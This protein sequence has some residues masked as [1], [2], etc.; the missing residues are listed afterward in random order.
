MELLLVGAG[1]TEAL[2]ARRVPR[3][4]RGSSVLSLKTTGLQA[5]SEPGEGL[6]R[7]REG[8]AETKLR[9]LGD[10]LDS[11]DGEGASRITSDLR[12]RETERTAGP[13]P[14]TQPLLGGKGGRRALICSS[15]SKTRRAVTAAGQ[16]AGC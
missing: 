9:K 11:R 1:G 6:V 7:G 3:G 13:L 14:E 4:L 5:G 2:D 10:G 8:C 16:P 12:V 15:G